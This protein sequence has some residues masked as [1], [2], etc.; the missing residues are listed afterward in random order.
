MTAK[1]L[2]S[3]L[4]RPKVTA[5]QRSQHSEGQSVTGLAQGVGTALSPVGGRQKSVL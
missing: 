2:H 5:V 4:A 3:L 1:N